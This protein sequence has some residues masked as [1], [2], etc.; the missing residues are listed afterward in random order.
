MK[1]DLNDLHL[2][3]LQIQKAFSDDLITSELLVMKCFDAIDKYDNILGSFLSLNREQALCAARQSDI[4]R[5]N[6]NQISLLDGIPIGIKDIIVTKNLCTTAGSKILKNFIPP[7][8]A[9]VVKKIK[10]SGGIII[11]KQN[12]D[13][14]AMGSS[15]EM[16]AYKLCRNPWNIH[17][18]SGGS[19]GGSAASII[20]SF[21]F[22]ALGTD[23]GGSVRQ[24][25]SFCGIVGVKPTYGL[26]S[27]FGII[28]YAS[29]LDQVGVLAKNVSSASIMLE[30]IAGYDHLDS[31]SISREVKC[32]RNVLTNDCSDLVVGVP[33]EYFSMNID[34][35]IRNAIINVINLLKKRGVTIKAISLPHTKYAIS[36][37]YII[38]SAE[39]ASNLSRY[40]GVHFGERS[41]HMNNLDDFYVHNRGDFFGDEVKKRIMLGT[42]VL[43]SGY[44]D[45]YYSKAQKFRRLIS[46]DFHLAFNH[47]NVILTPTTPTTAFKIGEKIHN[48]IDMYMNDVFTVASSL[49][50]LPALSL[51]IGF[52]KDNMPI[53]LQLIGNILDESVILNTAYCIER[54]LDINKYPNIKNISI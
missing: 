10:R 44:Y 1:L 14:F 41:T 13:E 46:N 29:S 8:D 37:Y 19:S 24:P 20:A 3:I 4:R 39:A 33:K 27:R 9:T 11:G 49:A 17:K 38:S 12:L 34:K 22:G 35:C 36:A 52:S 45:Q 47:V 30:T 51:P 25:A 16:S 18:T 6:G 32:Y 31:T 53:G 23:T 42:Y 2:D 28:A 50:G 21:C 40:D 54:D 15:N 26:V 48:T 43:S 5:K 7:Y